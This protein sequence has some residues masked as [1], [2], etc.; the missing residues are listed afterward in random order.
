MIL[1]MI[2]PLILGV[3]AFIATNDLYIS[4]GIVSVGLIYFLLIFPYLN[5]KPKERINRF[6]ECSSFINS[7]I[8][9]LNVNDSLVNAFI[10]ATLK[11]TPSFEHELEGINHLS[12]DEKLEYLSRYFYFDIYSLFL[13]TLEIHDKQGGNIID[14]SSHLLA[15]LR[16]TDSYLFESLKMNKS[17]LI[18]IIILWSTTLFIL[19]FLR[20][21]LNTFFN[22]LM[23][24]WIYKGGVIAF[25]VFT[26]ISFEIIRRVFYKV[27]LKEK[28][29]VED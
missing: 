26:Y 1:L 7:F 9:S 22:S 6:K 17:K 3:V 13:K 28:R 21:G 18:E 29:Y 2:I 15:E 19:A 23:K 24:N 12:I 14:C 25:F 10:S 4:I 5:K 20:F 11:I 8:I 27:D 16:N